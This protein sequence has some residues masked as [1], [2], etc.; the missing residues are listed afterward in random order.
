MDMP[1]RGLHHVTATVADA[2]K[3]L[4]FY[5]GVLG[6]RLVKKTVNFDNPHVYHFYYGDASGTPGTIMTTFPY[7]AMG[8]RI[9]LHGA[10]Q[11]TATSFSVP[12]DSLPFWR[13]R[14]TQQNI[15]F[16]DEHDGFPG[17]EAIQVGDPSGL[18]LRLV[19][20]DADARAPWTR[21]GISA[22]EAVRGIHSV[23]LTV[24]D[25]AETIAFIAAI[26]NSEVVDERA[27]IT[28]V[29]INGDTP[30][31]V[32]EVARAGA[33][34]PAAING[35][36]TVHHVAFAVDDED[37]QRALRERIA[38]LGVPVTEVLDRQYFRSIYFR[39][40]NGVL[41][42]VATIPPGFAID[43]TAAELG[44]AL[45]LPPWEEAN[46]AAI[47]AGLPKVRVP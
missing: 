27:G 40:P 7:K 35:L 30:G 12:A 39:E 2:Q 6:Q 37:Q 42:E 14:L 15:A 8:V 44:R 38:Q 41:F 22:A 47:E 43:E 4:D 32:V 29:A 34:V 18:V 10:G 24:R 36:G 11:I 13:E 28:R 20:S 25:P 26:M 19:A 3:D 9:G 5:A 17:E 1:I 16:E 21:P 46:R 31:R 23:R 33:D 45:K